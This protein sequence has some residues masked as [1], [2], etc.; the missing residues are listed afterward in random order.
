MSNAI[1]ESPL[2]SR[3]ALIILYSPRQHTKFGEKPALALAVRK[4]ASQISLRCPRIPISLPQCKQSWASFSI[5]VDQQG[6]G[7]ACLWPKGWFNIMSKP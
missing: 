1:Q 4:E 7:P 2:G 5:P 3:R 6:Q